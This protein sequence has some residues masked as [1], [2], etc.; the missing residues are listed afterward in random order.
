M[1]STNTLEI[2]YQESRMSLKGQHRSKTLPEKRFTRSELEL[3]MGKRHASMMH[4]MREMMAEFMRN[5]GQSEASSAEGSAAA[6]GSPRGAKPNAA[7]NNFCCCCCCCCWR[8]SARRYD[9][10]KRD[11]FD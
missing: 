2:W 6:G 9:S 8:R 4:A 1:D 10:R 7:R 5:N 11:D 3:M